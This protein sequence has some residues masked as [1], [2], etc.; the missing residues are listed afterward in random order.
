MQ[1]FDGIAVVL[2]GFDAPV[3]LG[4]LSSLSPVQTV[5]YPYREFSA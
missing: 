1:S 2:A 3:D 4:Y 5:T